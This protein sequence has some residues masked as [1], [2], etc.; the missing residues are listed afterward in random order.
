MMRETKGALG[1]GGPEHILYLDRRAR[2][3]IESVPLAAD[4]PRI[5]DP[6]IKIL[7]QAVKEANTLAKIDMSVPEIE[8][9]GVRNRFCQNPP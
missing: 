2:G 9:G 7:D 6:L 1:G 4:V 3:L 5:R 8:G